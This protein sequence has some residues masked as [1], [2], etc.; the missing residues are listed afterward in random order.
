MHHLQSYSGASFELAVP[1]QTRVRFSALMPRSLVPPPQMVCT[2]H[3]CICEWESNPHVGA[4]S[5]WQMQHLTCGHCHHDECVHQTQPPTC[6]KSHNNDLVTPTACQKTRPLS[7]MDAHM[8]T[9]LHNGRRGW[10]GGE[11]AKPHNRAPPR[12]HPRQHHSKVTHS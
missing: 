9:R 3:C 11:G 10:G 4:K 6:T 1:A 5:S 12:Q 8:L 7:T 2:S